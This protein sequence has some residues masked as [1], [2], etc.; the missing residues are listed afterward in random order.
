MLLVY[1]GS[2]DGLLCAVFDIYEKKLLNCASIISSD[3]LDSIPLCESLEVKNNSKHADRVERKLK[4]LGAGA[5]VYKAWLSKEAGIEDC[6]LDYIRTALKIQG[7]PSGMLYDKNIKRTVLAARHVSN[8][9]HRYLQFTRFI[10]VCRTREDGAV[11]SIYVGDIEPQY[12]ILHLIAKHFTK[13]FAAQ[14]FLIRDKAHGQTL[15][16]DTRSWYITELPGFLEP[17]LPGSEEFGEMWR[18]YF[19]ALSIPWRANKKL[20]QQLVP[21]K[22]RRYLT[23]FL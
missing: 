19:E 16:W 15:I 13:R 6:I 3:K 8:E 7:N 1:D 14:H 4:S 20:Q 10:K 21:R 11:L 23:E 22:Y 18:S 12:E 5:T 2:Y 17:A 9:A